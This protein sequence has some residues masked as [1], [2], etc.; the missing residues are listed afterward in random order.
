MKQ[1]TIFKIKNKKTN[2]YEGVYSRGYHDQYEFSSKDQALN[3]NCHGIHK[4]ETRYEIEE[5]LVTY[6]KVN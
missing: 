4:D 3:A 5:W 1:K 2:N 6:K